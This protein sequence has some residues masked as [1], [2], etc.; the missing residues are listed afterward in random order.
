MKRVL[1]W[2][3]AIL[4]CLV[5]A[6]T[7]L[8]V[9]T[10]GDYP[11]A[12]LVTDDPSRPSQ[13]VAGVQLHMRVVAGPE[14]APAIIVLHGGP[15]GDFRSLQA[16]EALS[17]HYE[18][19]FYDQRGAGLSERVSKDRLTLDGYLEELQGVIDLVSPDEPT[20][21]IGHSWGAMLAAA[22]LGRNPGGVRAAILIEPGYLDAAGHQAWR[23]ESEKYLSGIAYWRE[24]VLT[25]FRAQHVSGP[26]PAAAHDYLIGHMVR[27]FTN[28][29]EN[30][31]HCG[32]GYTSPN[33]RF[34]AQASEAWDATAEAELGQVAA[35]AATY[36]GPVLLL[37]GECNEW[38]GEARQI[39]HAA[40]FANA[41]LDVIPGAG[42]DVVWDNPDATLSVLRS[43]LGRDQ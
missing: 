31:Y 41:T 26:D 12:R 35:G 37:A 33:W 25:G 39:E 28:H 36:P 23:R 38:I 42:H 43:F 5:V 11:V 21:L 8:F 17:D 15:G 20:I 3:A 30:P 2:A 9:A 6:I 24:A 27:V 18:V 7:A 29:Q 4:L 10:R 40:Q 13:T 14:G 16:L 32:A 1:I 22:Y 34:G 19:V